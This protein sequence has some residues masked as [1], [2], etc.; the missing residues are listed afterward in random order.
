MASLATWF[1]RILGPETRPQAAR[2]G[3]GGAGHAVAV[4]AGEPGGENP[5]RV[6]AFPNDDVYF[7]VKRI[8]NSRVLRQSDPRA[9]QMCVRMVCI[10]C[11]VLFFLAGALLP[12]VY[13][14][15]AGYRIDAMARERERLNS[16]RRLLELEEARLLSPARLE[17]LARIQ[18]F[19]DPA[20]EKIIQLPPQ[21][22]EAVALRAEGR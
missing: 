19:V 17:E 20:P 15:L 8:D 1:D 5:Y 10:T 2:G 14:T 16:E 21:A 7:Y 3:G 18:R 13:G 11:L 4:G 9:R 12:K 6:R 22:D